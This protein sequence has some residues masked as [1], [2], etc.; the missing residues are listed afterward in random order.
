[1]EIQFKD[2]KIKIWREVARVFNPCFFAQRTR[3]EKPRATAPHIIQPA[4][5]DRCTPLMRDGDVPSPPFFRIDSPD[6][7]RQRAGGQRLTT[8][9]GPHPSA[10]PTVIVHLG[11]VN[12]LCDRRRRKGRRTR[13]AIDRPIV[14]PVR[15]PARAV[16]AGRRQPM[17]SRWCSSSSASGSIC[18]PLRFPLVDD[19]FF[20][21]VDSRRCSPPAD[22]DE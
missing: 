14:L 16:L 6:V 5:S 20:L 22:V 12:L 11:D 2:L 7:S 8:A 18:R 17:N 15:C 4:T 9:Y 1:M 10:A 21:P 3:V 13:G 19:F